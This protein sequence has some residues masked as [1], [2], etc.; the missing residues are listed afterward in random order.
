MK[1]LF[2]TLLFVALALSASAADKLNVVATLPDLGAIAAQVGG[3]LIQ[4]TTLANPSEDPHFVDPKPSFARVLN[5]A[6]LL[7]EGGADLEAGWL[8]PIVQNARNA[9]ILPGQQGRFMASV[10]IEL[11]DRPIGP[12]DRSQGDVHPGGNPHYL[13]DP[14]NA[15]IV[16]HN[17]AEHLGKLDSAHAAAFKENADKF[18]GE[19]TAQ[20]AQWSQTVAAL[21]GAKVITYHR[22]F[23]YLLERFGL[24]LF[25]TLEPKPGIEPSPTHIADLIRRSKPAGIKFILIEDN[26][27]RK[28]PDKVAQEIGAKVV[29]LRHMPEATGQAR[30]AAWISGMIDAIDKA[31]KTK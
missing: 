12:V 8:A 13:M 22:S 1:R 19:I 24:E 21:K 20:L 23:N 26:R 28:T 2:F 27:S 7:I 31:N 6:D 3:D 30:Y 9:K 10:G 17:L 14:A 16:A 11:K 5:K 25:A 4:L 29:V 15:I 18:K